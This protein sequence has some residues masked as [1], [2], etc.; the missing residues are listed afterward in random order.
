MT[1]EEKKELDPLGIYTEEELSV[2][3]YIKDMPSEVKDAMSKLTHD[4][5]NNL[6]NND[7]NTRR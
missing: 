3:Q 7:T 6:P 4:S 2:L 5:I 1:Q